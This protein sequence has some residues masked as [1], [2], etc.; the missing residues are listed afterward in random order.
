MKCVFFTADVEVTKGA[1]AIA[2]NG[3]QAAGV[4]VGE[5]SMPWPYESWLLRTADK[6]CALLLVMYYG[7]HC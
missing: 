5:A 4:A 3:Q 6:M 1:S 7:G 2:T